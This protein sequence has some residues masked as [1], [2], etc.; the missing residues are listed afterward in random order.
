MMR[1][2]TDMDQLVKDCRRLGR[3]ETEALSLRWLRAIVSVLAVWGGEGA[4]RALM[5]GV[6]G[7]LFSGGGTKGNSLAKA[8]DLAPGAAA[9]VAFFAEVGRRAG[10]E[11]PGKMAQMATAA[12]ALIKQ[13]LAADQVSA[14]LS[15]LPADIAAEVRDA[16]VEPPWGYG[17]IP[18]SYARP[19]RKSAH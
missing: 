6:P 4:A 17:L 2:M 13:C 16:T 7:G 9:G 18:Q 1:A 3:V 14:L 19:V 10:Q 5:T 12:L 11:D 8:Q 15:A